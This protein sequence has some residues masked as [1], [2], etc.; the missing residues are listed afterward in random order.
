M[1][2]MMTL[3]EGRVLPH[4]H[5]PRLPLRPRIVALSRQQRRNLTP[6]A[7]EDRL[8]LQ[9]QLQPTDG[10]EMIFRR[11]HRPG[12]RLAALRTGEI[13][14]VHRESGTLR[15]VGAPTPVLQP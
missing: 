4:Q 10:C 5:V 2:M 14:V 7:I 8:V 13:E 11:A 6:H 12:L 9:R 15:I 3:G 1:M